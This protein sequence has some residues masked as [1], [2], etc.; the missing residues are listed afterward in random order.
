MSFFFSFQINKKTPELE[1]KC[2]DVRKIEGISN[3]LFAPKEKGT[4]IFVLKTFLP[5]ARC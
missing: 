2:H 1:I 3:I 4:I 5:Q